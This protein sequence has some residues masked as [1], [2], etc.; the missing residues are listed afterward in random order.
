MFRGG[1]HHVYKARQIAKPEVNEA[2]KYTFSIGKQH[3]N[4]GRMNNC[5]QHNLPQRGRTKSWQSVPRCVPKSK[6]L[7]IVAMTMT[8]V[9]VQEML[10]MC[11]G[12]ILVNMY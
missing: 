11:L 9:S 10:A 6:V 7:I 12:A 2:E 5:D 4:G 1:I 8:L 3:E